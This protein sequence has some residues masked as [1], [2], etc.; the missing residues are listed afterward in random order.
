LL[1]WEPSAVWLVVEVA[2]AS[3]VNLNGKVKFPRGN[4]VHCGTRLS[5]TSYLAERAPGHVIVGG[6]ATAG[7]RGTATAGDDGTATAGYAGTA[8]AGDDGTATAGYAGT[9][10]AGARGT[11]LI[12]WYDGDRYR[13]ATFYVGEDGVLPNRAYRVDGAGKRVLVDLPA[14]PAAA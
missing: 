9:A 5:A 2:T 4:V 13:I 14:V 8:T 3:F 1:N 11:L 12:R 7:A 10:T 6:T